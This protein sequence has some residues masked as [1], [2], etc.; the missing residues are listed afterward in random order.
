MNYS[1]WVIPSESVNITLQK[2][3]DQLSKEFGGPLFE[4]HMTIIGGI[5]QGLS[6]IE[7]K[8]YKIA[9]TLNTLELTLGPVSFST[10]YFQNVLVRVN[11]TALL[12]QL[13]LDFKK[14]FGEENSVFMP[15]ISLLY[16]NQNMET[17]ERATSAFRLSPLTFTSSE[18]IITPSTPNPS[19]WKHAA[20]IPFGSK[21]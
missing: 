11:S 10:T 21:K 13:N 20:A 16:G 17:R 19:D 3:I 6:E 9:Q 7:E 4:P 14:V 8:T 1:I 5:N 2:I 18:F 15:H 12:M